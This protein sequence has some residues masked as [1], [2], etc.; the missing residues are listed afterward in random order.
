MFG[1]YWLFLAFPRLL[2]SLYFQ[3][4]TT[5]WIFIAFILTCYP[6][7]LKQYFKKAE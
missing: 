3:E 7:N 2:L 4:E 5:I 1:I 6:I